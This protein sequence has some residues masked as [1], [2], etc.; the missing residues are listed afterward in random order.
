[1]GREGNL[2]V[3]PK[4]DWLDSPDA[5]PHPGDLPEWQTFHVITGS[6]A[7]AL[8]GLMFVVIA[9]NTRAT[10]DSLEGGGHAFGTPIVL[11]FCAVLLLA[12]VASIPHQTVTSLSACV[13]VTGLC[14]MAL[15]TR[16]AV[17]ARR[18]S[19]YSPVP[20]DWVWHVLMPFVAYTMAVAAAVALSRHLELALNLIAAGSLLL[21]FTGI[22]NAWDSAV[23]IAA[24]AR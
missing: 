8:T 18:Q 1:M 20:S 11:H 13:G 3:G 23:Y 5:R 15:S 24:K 16:V 17:R 4:R 9:L 19:S 2:H 21:L 10:I 7:A 12:A 6:A 22:R 14:G